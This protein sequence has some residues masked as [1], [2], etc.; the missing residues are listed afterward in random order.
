[1]PVSSRTSRMQV[2][3]SDSSSVSLEPVTLCQK[4]GCV[5]ALDQQHVERGR[6]DDDEDGFGDLESSFG[7]HGLDCAVARAA[8]SAGRGTTLM[9]P[10][11][12]LCAG[13]PP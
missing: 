13:S 5:G 7:A 6:V 2:S 12:P 4:P 1:M 9:S 10:E 8:V 11:P 3:T